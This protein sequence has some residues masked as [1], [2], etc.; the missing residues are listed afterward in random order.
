MEF[1]NS[2]LGTHVEQIWRR[3]VVRSWHFRLRMHSIVP[4]SLPLFLCM[5]PQP[6]G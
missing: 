2:I 1:R 5:P 3:Q 6:P 4:H